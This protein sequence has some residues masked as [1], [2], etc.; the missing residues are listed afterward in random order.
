MSNDVLA[1]SYQ[2]FAVLNQDPLHTCLFNNKCK[3]LSNKHSK[4]PRN[5]WSSKKITVRNFSK[6]LH[7]LFFSQESFQSAASSQ[8]TPPVKDGIFLFFLFFLSPLVVFLEE[9][10][11]ILFTEIWRRTPNETQGP[12]KTQPVNIQQRNT[13]SRG[14]F[15]Q[16]VEMIWCIDRQTGYWGPEEFRRTLRRAVSRESGRC[17]EEREI[18]EGERTCSCKNWWRKKGCSCGEERKVRNMYRELEGKKRKV[19]IVP[20]DKIFISKFSLK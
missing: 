2:L 20:I 1:I 14:V 12:H 5:I 6:F 17:G 15:Q 7:Q 18:G 11:F 13:A 19:L 3:F 10:S 4:F 8:L 16:K 9:F